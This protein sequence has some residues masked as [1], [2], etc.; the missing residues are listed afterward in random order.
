MCAQAVAA[1]DQQDPRDDRPR[2]ELRGEIHVGRAVVGGQQPRRAEDVATAEADLR[3]EE[4]RVGRRTQQRVRAQQRIDA[5]D[6]T[7]L[8]GGI[9][10]QSVQRRDVGDDGARRDDG[11]G[12]PVHH[13]VQQ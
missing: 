8:A 11:R 10:E 6:Q 7:S 5:G 9:A 4:A 2:R 13:A 1:D 3:V 12:A